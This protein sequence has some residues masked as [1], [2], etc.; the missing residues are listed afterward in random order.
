MKGPTVKEKEQNC[1]RNM[2]FYSLNCKRKEHKFDNDLEHKIEQQ[3]ALL[4]V[5]ENQGVNRQSF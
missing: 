4:F 3:H 1:K 5:K 2:L